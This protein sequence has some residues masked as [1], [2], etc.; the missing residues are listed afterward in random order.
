MV[1]A[2]KVSSPTASAAVARKPRAD[3]VQSRQA[4][5]SAAADLATVR[6]LEGL[7][8]GELAKHVGMSKSGLYAH[9]K[10]KEELELATIDTAAQLFQ[11]TVLDIVPPTAAGLDRIHD[12]TEAF[13]SHLT[14]RVFA[15]GCFFAAVGVQL[16]PRPGPARNRVMQFI[17]DWNVLFSASLQQAQSAGHIAKDANFDQLAFEITAML[18]RA[19][20]AWVVS[21]NP[22]VLDQARTGIQNVLQHAGPKR[23]SKVRK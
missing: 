3:G 11:Q 13:L 1:E 6:G 19:N 12:L 18:F 14:R 23:K 21:N 17:S 22:A 20:F 16:A 5:L 2:K 9:F 8:I 7:S 15:G 10:S 4:I